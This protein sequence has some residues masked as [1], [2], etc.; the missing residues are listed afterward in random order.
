VKGFTLIELLVVIA[1]VGIL[2]AIAV[3]TY[4]T[5]SHKAYYTEIINAASPYV[6]GVNLCYQVT[7]ALTSCT[8]G[9][10]G[11]PSN[12][13]THTGGVNSLTVASG[14]VTVTPFAQNGL[15]AADTYVL[16]PSISNTHVIW[17]VSG[18]CVAK[19]YC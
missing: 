5:Y 14:V 17:A 15:V 3:P 18:G 6:L 10:N 8:G 13:S 4:T 7:G 12:I 16:T 2:A 9:T 11:V 1:I 19:G